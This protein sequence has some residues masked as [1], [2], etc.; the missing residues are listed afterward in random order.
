MFAKKQHE[1]ALDKVIDEAIRNLDPNEK[2]YLETI[3]AIERLHKLKEQ[4]C[5]RVSP[6]TAAIVAGNIFGIVLILRYEQLHIVTSKALS[7]VLKMK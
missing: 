5:W 2:N 6:D 7:F 3:E 4:S 1:V